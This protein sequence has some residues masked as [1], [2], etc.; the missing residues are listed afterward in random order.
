MLRG[1]T[2]WSPCLQTDQPIAGGHALAALSTPAIEY[3]DLSQGTSEGCGA[4]RRSVSSRT[5][6]GVTRQPGRSPRRFRL[7]PAFGCVRLG[8]AQVRGAKPVSF[9]VAPRFPHKRGLTIRILRRGRHSPRPPVHA[10]QSAR[11]RPR[12]SASPE[13]RSFARLNRRGTGRR[14]RSRSAAI[15]AGEEHV[16]PDTRRSV[17]AE[18]GKCDCPVVLIAGNHDPLTPGRQLR[19]HR[20]A[21][22]R[23]SD[24][25]ET[26]QSSTGFR[27][28]S[29]SGE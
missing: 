8:A 1:S 25:S 28:R 6:F 15:S 24:G 29:A 4:S 26:R 27:M 12:P 2:R 14:T 19:A 3:V 10:G 9:R 11:R 18:L 13:I 17:A 5:R 21:E 16:S 20:L 7:S 22:Q 23:S